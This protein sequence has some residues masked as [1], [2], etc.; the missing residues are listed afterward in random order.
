MAAFAAL[1]SASKAA[2]CLASCDDKTVTFRYRES[3]PNQLK[4]RTLSGVEFLRLLLQHILPRGFRRARD[5]GF[6]HANS[7]R[8]I[9]QLQLKL[10]ISPM[11]YTPRTRPPF[12]CACWGG[13]KSVIKARVDLRQSAK[14]KEAPIRQAIEV[15]GEATT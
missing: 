12:I 6:L 4:T 9:T 1:I 15:K 7:K 3:E 14:P 10:R 8:M 13:I 11:P 5:F 2:C